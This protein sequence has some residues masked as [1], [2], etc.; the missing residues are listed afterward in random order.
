MAKS[1]DGGGQKSILLTL[2][3][4][5]QAHSVTVCVWRVHYKLQCTVDRVSSGEIYRVAF[6]VETKYQIYLHKYKIVLKKFSYC[7]SWKAHQVFSEKLKFFTN[8]TNE[9]HLQVCMHCLTKAQDC[10]KV[11]IWQNGSSKDTASLHSLIHQKCS[12]P[13][14]INVLKESFIDCILTKF[15][16]LL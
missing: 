9:T 11:S 12:A 13:K 2:F 16:E 3:P 15:T 10:V 1:I 5:L 4:I 8:T 7:K 14:A 6:L